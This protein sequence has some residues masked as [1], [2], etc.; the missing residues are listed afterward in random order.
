[1]LRMKEF[2]RFRTSVFASQFSAARL[3][4]RGEHKRQTSEVSLPLL[5]LLLLWG[6]LD[7]K[8][9][10]FKRERR[11]KT[12]SGHSVVTFLIFT[13]LVIERFWGP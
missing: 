13:S 3:Q 12:R 5:L 1:M 9:S 2:R 11:G 4:L 6:S 7:R 10:A 8:F